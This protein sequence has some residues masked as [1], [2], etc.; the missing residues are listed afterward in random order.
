MAGKEP[1]FVYWDAN[2]FISLFNGGRDRTPEEMDAIKYLA[3]RADA[4]EVTIVTS[5]LTYAEVL[6]ATSAGGDGLTPAQYR[7]FD[8]FM[9]ARVAISDAHLGVMRRTKI[10]RERNREIRTQPGQEHRLYLNH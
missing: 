10:I 5:G 3:D 1:A 8:Q 2:V 9:Q 7:Q 4:G 6:E